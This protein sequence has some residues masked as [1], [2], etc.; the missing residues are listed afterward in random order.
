MAGHAPN[1][2][3]ALANLRQLCEEHLKGRYIVEVVDVVKN[4]EAAVENNVLVTP[5]LILIAPLPKVVVL[6]N[7]SDRPKV[8]LALRLWGGDT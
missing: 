7:L 6:G 8:L 1:S 3:L 2:K 5:T 4:F